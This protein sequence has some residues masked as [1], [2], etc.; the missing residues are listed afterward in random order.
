MDNK[1][2][3][4]IF[5]LI[6]VVITFFVSYF[7]FNE[8]YNKD[9]RLISSLDIHLKNNTS[10]DKDNDVNVATFILSNDSAFSINYKV[11]V[12]DNSNKKNGVDRKYVKYKLKLG[13]KIIKSGNFADLEDNILM[14]GAIDGKSKYI[15]SLEL[16]LD[17]N[18][19]LY[20]KYYRC[21]L[22]IEPIM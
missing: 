13:N 8:F 6:L 16:T 21:D 20:D 5:I 22:T 2:K 18:A 4:V 1:I 10:L 7:S 19:D 3:M 9:L 11:L 17:E 14:S 15:Y 12:N